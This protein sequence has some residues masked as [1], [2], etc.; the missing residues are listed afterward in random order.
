ML[1]FYNINIY[2]GGYFWLYLA[3]TNKIKDGVLNVCLKTCWLGSD[4]W[5]L[6]KQIPTVH[7]HHF[8]FCQFLLE[9][10]FNGVILG[11]DT[12]TPTVLWYHT[13]IYTEYF[14]KKAEQ[15][16]IFIIIS[17]P[18]TLGPIWVL[19][20]SGLGVDFVSTPHSL[21]A[22]ALV[23]VVLTTT[24]GATKQLSSKL[25]YLCAPRTLFHRYMYTPSNISQ[26]VHSVHTA[27]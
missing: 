2:H 1:S 18:Q 24:L 6:T 15:L 22:L 12:A 14:N 25:W 20:H 13:H 27:L 26:M 3:G 11:C 9:F 4:H 23:S 16:G 17:T 7:T 19:K 8:T 5:G 21:D 10:S